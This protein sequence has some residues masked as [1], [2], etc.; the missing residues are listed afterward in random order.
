MSVLVHVTFDLEGADSQDY[1]NVRNGLSEIA[2]LDWVVGD[3]KKFVDLPC[4]TFLAEYEGNY[5]ATI[6]DDVSE[7]IKLLFKDLGVKG[8]VFVSVGTGWA[9]GQTVV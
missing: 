2:L 6:R 7:F 5:S 8:K 9:W 4:N 3:N 1:E